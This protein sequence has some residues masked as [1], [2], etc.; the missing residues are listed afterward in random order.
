MAANQQIPTVNPANE[1]VRR[2]KYTRWGI[3]L[4]VVPSILGLIGIAL[5]FVSLIFSFTDSTERPLI[6]TVVSTLGGISMG[7]A[8]FTFL[9]GIIIG[10]VLLVLRPK[11]S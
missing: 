4:L 11:T 5:F 9:P 6:A 8:S 1:A 3:I 7:I 10:A 2:A